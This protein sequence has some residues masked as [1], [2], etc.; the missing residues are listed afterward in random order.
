[1]KK[2]FGTGYFLAS[3]SKMHGGAQK[4]VY[5]IDCRDGFSCVLYVWD[6]A[7]NYFQAEKAAEDIN[8]RSYGSD[9]FEMNSKYL[10]QHGIR[11]PALYDLNKERN[12]Y[13]FDYALVEYV[14]GSKA[15]AYFHHSDSRVKDKVLQQLGDMLAA[16]HANE[17][18]TYGKVNNS[19]GNTANAHSLKLENAKNQLSYASQYIDSFRANQSKLL[20]TLY[21]L[22]S[23]I[24]PRNRY[25]FIHGE[26]GP[27][28][29]LV[30]DNLE[31]YL[32]DIEGAAFFDIE[33]EHS[34]LEFRFGDYYRYLKNDSLDP[35]RM[36]FYRFHHH[37]SL[38]SGGLKLLHRG[39]PDQQFAKELAEHHSR[40]AM[41]FIEG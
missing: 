20:D 41:R 23:T 9:L 7:M 24:E 19:G 4:V 10:S 37:I 1:M 3:V 33:H 27:D 34:F 11:T 22:E 5:K 17:R 30:N 16:M 28:H 35:N 21:M 13:P 36:L 38:T 31:P 2:V 40:C 32:I 8:E 18:H 29:V 15:E 25:G 12:R 26:L 39:F 14:D 6:L